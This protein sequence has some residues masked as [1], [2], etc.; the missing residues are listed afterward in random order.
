MHR[1]SEND[2]RVE[3][4]NETS[5]SMGLWTG[6]ICGSGLHAFVLL[7]I[8]LRT[9]WEQEENKAKERVFASKIPTEMPS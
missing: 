8:T 4:A 5:V 6:I 1:Q 2:D 9:N 7:V 3:E